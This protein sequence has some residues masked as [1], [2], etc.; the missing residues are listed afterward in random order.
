[1]RLSATLMVKV[2]MSEGRSFCFT[3]Q[4]KDSDEPNVYQAVLMG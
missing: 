4:N 3:K 1:M 2:R